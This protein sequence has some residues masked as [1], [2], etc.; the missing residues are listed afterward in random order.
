MTRARPVKLSDQYSTA[1]AWYLHRSLEKRRRGSAEARGDVLQHGLRGN[2][3][4]LEEHREDEAGERGE[5][6]ECCDPRCPGA[7]AT[8]PRRR[9]SS[10]ES[11][12]RRIVG[13][14]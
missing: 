13:L 8:P 3:D 11:P 10:G 1:M 12:I 7:L 5:D 6:E 14:S 2:H 9:R 4:D